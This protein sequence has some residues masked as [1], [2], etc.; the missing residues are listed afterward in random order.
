MILQSLAR[1]YQR[2][3]ERNTEGVAPYGFS[4]EKISYAIVLSPDG[5]CVQVQDIRNTNGKKP[6]P[7]LLLV[8]AP[9][10][11]AGTGSKA[12]FL[13]DKS[14]YVLGVSKDPKRAIQNHSAF[15]KLHEDALADTDDSGLNAFLVFLR[16]WTPERFVAPHFTDEMLD[17]NFVFKL[18]GENEFL[19]DRRAARRAWDHFQSTTSD[20]RNGMCLVTG[21]RADLARLH[22]SIK[23]FDSTGSSIVAFNSDAY[24]SYRGSLQKIL[25]K[26]TE[27]DSGAS[28]PISKQA[29]FAYTTALNY[30]LRR[31]EHNRQRLQIGDTT[32]VFWAESEDADT[33]ASAELTLAD[34]LDPP[35]DDSNQ[36]ARV[37]QVLGGIAKGRP[38]A[39]IDPGLAEGT[40]MYVLGLAPNA[41]RLSI[42]FWLVDTLGTLARRI[43]Q[44][45]A[46]LQLAPSPWRTEPSV[47]RL[48][49]ATAPSRWD[50]KSKKYRP[51]K[52]HVLPQLAGELM[53]AILTGG[54]YPG[55]LLANTI[56]RMRSDGDI[57]GIRVALCKAVLARNLRIQSSQ[58]EIPVS[59]DTQSTQPAYLLG[60]LFAVLEYAQRSALGT[61]VNATIRDRYYGSASSMPAAIFPILLRNT[62]N[63]LSKLRK[64]HPGLAGYIEKQILEIVAGLSEQFPRSLR[65]EDQGR[66]AI[67][68]YHQKR[69]VDKD[70]TETESDQQGAQS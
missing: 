42:R 62:K 44:H 52:K 14:S 27:N 53:R 35:A 25:S 33:A 64:E 11:R 21:E 15:R 32:V 38:L 68:Y 9:S 61:Q 20:T 36:T 19:H 26:K 65:I 28:A 56:M 39:E 31:G 59:L 17:A 50:E 5:D 51:D 7:E 37:R 24:L 45:R 34:M 67:G 12:F 4:S 69:G 16:E 43:V 58:E 41:S 3:I 40:R 46:D 8:P 1:Y 63:H 49:L 60:R 13:W 6:Q 10:K 70:A 55:S 18:D 29:A 30:L 47:W 66:F 23:G 2:L 48:A 57:S 22:P 54:R